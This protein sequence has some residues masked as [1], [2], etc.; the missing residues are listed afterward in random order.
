MVHKNREILGK[1]QGGERSGTSYSQRR[2][3]Q[4]AVQKDG[5]KGKQASV[6]NQIRSVSRQIKKG[7]LDPG[8]VTALEQRLEI[9]NRT[10]D[11]N[12]LSE[13]TRKNAVRYHKVRFFERVKLERRIQKLEH[14]SKY[15]SSASEVA[16]RT[17][18]LAQLRDDLQ[19]V[20]HFPKEEKYVSII[21]KL[22]D[23]EAAAAVV[24][25]L[26]RLKA[27]VHSRLR[28]AA[29]L[30]DADEGASLPQPAATDMQ[31]AQMSGDEQDDFFLASDDDGKREPAA[32]AKQTHFSRPIGHSSPLGQ[33]EGPTQHR[34]SE[35]PH[36]EPDSKA[37]KG[38]PKQERKEGQLPRSSASVQKPFGR[39]SAP[40]PTSSEPAKQPSQRLDSRPGGQT[41]KTRTKPRFSRLKPPHSSY[42]S[43]ILPKQTRPPK[44]A[45]S[46]S[47]GASQQ[48]PSARTR[49]EGGRKRRK[50]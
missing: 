26:T 5:P 9:L 29:L 25:Q 30:A 21:Q 37:K 20:L 41:F 32:D 48:T 17:A 12:K 16:A 18:Q 49:A 7:G 15:D 1:R 10:L 23:P 50:K 46:A 42:P 34:N 27:I 33:G 13:K 6:K 19:Y 2:G 8:A 22:E 45:E 40:L 36:Q 38:R 4:H 43:H 47:F 24:A 35:V 44:P 28:D 3:V 14:E 11:G 39:S 31:A